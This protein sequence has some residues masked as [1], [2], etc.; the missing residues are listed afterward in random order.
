MPAV[1]TVTEPLGHGTGVRRVLD[2]HVVAPLECAAD[3][4]EMADVAASLGA[5]RTPA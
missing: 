2:C 5:A 1:S 3:L 4:A